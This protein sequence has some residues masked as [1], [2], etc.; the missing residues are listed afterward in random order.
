MGPA[1]VILFWAVLAAIYGLIF[2]FFAGFFILSCVKRWRLLKWLTGIPAAG[3]VLLAISIAVI[4]AFMFTYVFFVSMSPKHVFKDTFGEPPSSKIHDIQSNVWFFADT[5]SIYLTFKTSE[6]EFRRLVPS[7]LT[8]LKMKEMRQETPS[9][10]G[11]DPP[12]WWTYRYEPDWIYFLCREMRRGDLRKKGFASETEYYAYDPD[13]KTA[14][15]RFLG[16]D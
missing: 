12:S 2:L 6:S 1:F 14:Y 5:G 3:M 9:E 11:T 7:G 16:I 4:M 8:E 15:Y 10:G 13:T